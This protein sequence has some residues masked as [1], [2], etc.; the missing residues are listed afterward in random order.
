MHV[1]RIDVCL[2]PSL[3]PPP[4]CLLRP[5][6]PGPG[7]GVR[8]QDSSIHLDCSLR[9][10]SASV[11]TIP[12]AAGS[13]VSPPGW[14]QSLGSETGTYP[15]PRAD[16]RDRRGRGSGGWPRQVHAGPAEEPAMF[17]QNR[18]QPKGRGRWTAPA[19]GPH[20]G[21]HVGRSRLRPH[22]RNTFQQAESRTSS[23]GVFVRRK[24]ADFH[25]SSTF[26]GSRSPARDSLGFLLSVQGSVHL[27]HMPPLCCL[28]L[29]MP[30]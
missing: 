18:R 22:E 10:R 17:S 13:Q 16:E 25:C 12:P 28:L 4:S 24:R 15:T 9:W 26:L 14:L 1:H 7:R 8:Q 30:A 27:P 19:F 23:R 6:A 2:L 29:S 5:P 21:C 20:R 11:S 3:G